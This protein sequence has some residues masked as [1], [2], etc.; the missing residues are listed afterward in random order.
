V[1]IFEHGEMS[2]DLT[3]D[4]CDCLSAGRRVGAARP[5]WRGRCSLDPG[6]YLDLLSKWCRSVVFDKRQGSAKIRRR[7]KSTVFAHR[8]NPCTNTAQPMIGSR[9]RIYRFCTFKDD[10]RDTCVTW[11]VTSLLC[12]VV[13]LTVASYLGYRYMCTRYVPV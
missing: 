9:C 6:A 7:A 3:I 11:T 12:H 8:Y 13:V 4:F 5:A 2:D 1:A 10:F